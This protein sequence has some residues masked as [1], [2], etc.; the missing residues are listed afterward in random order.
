MTTVLP[1]L[2]IF[3][4][5]PKLHQGKQRLA[6][7]TSPEITLRIAESLLAC[8]IEDAE[9]WQGNVVVACSSKNDIKWAKSKFSNARVISQTPFETSESIFNLGER[10]NYV[11]DKLRSQGHQQLIMIGT[12]APILNQTHFDEVVTALT[13]NDIALSHADDG[14][15][16]IM[17]NNLYWPDLSALPWSTNIL[18]DSLA[19]L[20]SVKELN[21]RYTLSGYDIDYVSDLKKVFID[22]QTDNRTA[23]KALVSLIDE[24]FHF[25]GK[26]SHV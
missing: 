5:R 19:Q 8:V 15:V 13:F 18:S 7:D 2:V 26:V 11:D 3:C 9:H 4:K 25:S 24:L 20:C 6:E 23:R 22:L 12:D 1:T 21:V 17:A 10:L 14:G 16:V